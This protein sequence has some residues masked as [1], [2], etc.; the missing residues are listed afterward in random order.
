MPRK[1]TI[2][3]ETPK[4]LHRCTLH[5]KDRHHALSTLGDFYDYKEV[6]VTQHVR[7]VEVDV[8]Y[9]LNTELP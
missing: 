3:R 1:D 4:G 6:S 8:Y 5:G 9:W 2:P 7:R